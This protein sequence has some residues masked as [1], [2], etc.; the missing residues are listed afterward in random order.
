M[1]I[2]F[3]RISEILSLARQIQKQNHKYTNIQP[4]AYIYTYI[5]N[6]NISLQK[7]KE[8]GYME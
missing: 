8:L 4:H 1:T 7:V 5:L 2:S 3:H 6:F